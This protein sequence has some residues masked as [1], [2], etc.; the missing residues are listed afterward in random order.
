[1][2]DVI[3]VLARIDDALDGYIEWRGRRAQTDGAVQDRVVIPRDSDL[4]HPPDLS[5]A[6]KAS[7]QL[8]V[9]A[10]ACWSANKRGTEVCGS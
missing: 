9:P 2:S 6:A 3:S 8:V 5:G 4:T 10:S 1:M 7:G